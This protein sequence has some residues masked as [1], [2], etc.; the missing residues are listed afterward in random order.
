MVLHASPR[1]PLQE[2]PRLEQ[3]DTLLLRVTVEDDILKAESL[4]ICD[5]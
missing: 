1:Q 5:P 3:A 4:C 2:G